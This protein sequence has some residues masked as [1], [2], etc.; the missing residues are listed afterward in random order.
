MGI[1]KI[2]SKNP[3]PGVHGPLGTHLPAIQVIII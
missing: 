1:N 3:G 2:K